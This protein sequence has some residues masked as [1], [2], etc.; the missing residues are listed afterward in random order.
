MR[1]DLLR[2]ISRSA[3]HGTAKKQAHKPAA[4][5]KTPQV[6]PKKPAKQS[7]A[8]RSLETVLIILI[9]GLIYF[10]YIYGELL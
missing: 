8:S 9:V 10:L 5:R 3:N 1:E 4:A 7:R 6:S 2:G